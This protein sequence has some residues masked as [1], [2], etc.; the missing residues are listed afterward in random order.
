[1]TRFLTAC[2]VSLALVLIAVGC[3]H[4]PASSQP[5][6]Y[7]YVDEDAAKAA[8]NGQAFEDPSKTSSLGAV[9]KQS[10]VP[11]TAT[12]KKLFAVA[13]AHPADKGA[14]KAYVT[15]T[16]DLALR[17]QSCAELTPHEKYPTALRLYRQLLSIDPSNQEAQGDAQQ[18]VDIYHSM[19][20]PVPN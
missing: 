16:L 6:N 4:P 19:G 9:T 8:Q 10:L 12:Q 2:S 20:R 14:A 11:L 3:G 13:K 18:I 17:I 7:H 5:T 1:M 15:A